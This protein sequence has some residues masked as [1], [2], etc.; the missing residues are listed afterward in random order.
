M[1]LQSKK[2]F[3]PLKQASDAYVIFVS[4]LP[5]KLTGFLKELDTA[6]EGQIQ[7]LI[8]DCNITSK[9]LSECVIHTH[10]KLPTKRIVFI[11]LGESP[12]LDIL[13]QAGGQAVR[14]AK[15]LHC[16]DV[17]FAIDGLDSKNAAEIQAL[18][19]GCEMGYYQFTRFKKQRDDVF[20]VASV[21][22]IGD[23]S[24]IE[25][26]RI[27]GQSVNIARDL[28][29]RPA[30][31][32]TPDSFIAHAKKHFAKSSVSVSVIDAKKAKQLG[33]NGLLAVG[34]GSLYPPAM[35]VLE[36]NN[37]P[38]QK[39][40]ALVGKGVTFDTGGISIKPGK[41]MSDMKGDM[42]GAAAVFGAFNA[43]SQL[44]KKVHILGL[45]PLAENMPSSK[46]QRPGDILTMMNGTTVEVINTDAEGRLILADALHY[47]VT[48]GA[49]SILDIAT[50]TG[51]C[52]VALGNES[53]A[54][55]G[56][57]DTLISAMKTASQHTGEKVWQMPLFD[58]FLE[59]IK[60]PVADIMNAVETK[61]GGVCTAAKFLEQFVGK[62]PWIHVDMA[63]V[64]SNGSTKGYQVKGM[65]GYGVRTLVEWVSLIL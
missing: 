15:R 3:N 10:P 64:M 9:K 5:K 56:N 12:S 49:K 8:K 28:A 11:G 17:V 55:L 53:A 32:L 39:P 50:L 26:G 41:G 37:A 30:N 35:L 7:G 61:G 34:Q 20:N 33:M 4:E 22:L 38:K 44:K 48:Q 46:A 59:Y 6:L 18:S 19:E 23:E 31:D 21:S 1:K 57:D 40:T 16:S 25:A 60:S 65:S 36:Y 29:N 52:S 54:I 51:A 14:T 13:R 63:S 42:G 47:T 45:I 2:S 43:L 58:E 62:T 27:I 24:A